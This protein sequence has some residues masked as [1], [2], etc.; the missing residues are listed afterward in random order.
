MIHIASRKELK[1]EETSQEMAGNPH[2]DNW[3]RKFIYYLL[4]KKTWNSL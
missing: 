4:S 3:E 2:I 1:Q